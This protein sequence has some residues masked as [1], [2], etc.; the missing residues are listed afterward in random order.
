MK[1]YIGVTC[2]YDPLD[3]I[4]KDT[5]MGLP[6]QDWNYVAGDNIYCLEEAGAVPV[7]IPYCRNTENLFAILETLDG[8]LLTGG[9]DID[10]NIYG[11]RPM[12]HCGRVIMERDAYDLL[13]ARYCYDQKL[14]IL[15]MC[16][17][18]QLLNVSR[19]GTLYQ[20]LGKE[21][22]LTHC[23]MGNV[24]PRNYR[25]HTT[26]F[27]PGSILHRI[28]GDQVRTNSFHHQGV[29]EPGENVEVTALAEDGAVEG[30]EISGG[31]SFM[32]GVQWH[33]EMMYDAEDQKAL[34]RAFVDACKIRKDGVSRG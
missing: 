24:G 17:G 9:T 12:P 27:T 1:P 4:S 15:G 22:G 8:I 2:N 26:S 11:K 13:I 30:I 18:I 21:A 19:G 20:D 29:W 16:R 32:V 7:M 14:P 28:F 33:P 25:V 6:G 3:Q 23:Y 10:P 34:F 31:A 5:G